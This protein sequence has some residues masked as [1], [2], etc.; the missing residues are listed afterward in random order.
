MS[1]AQAT[2]T[3]Y[4]KRAGGSLTWGEFSTRME[5]IFIGFRAVCEKRRQ[6]ESA[7][8]S[9]RL[10]L[11]QFGKLL[12]SRPTSLSASRPSSATRKR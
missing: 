12:V 4:P 2:L 9:S 6:T 10:S 5:T 1:Q 11:E 8:G 7:E 3:S